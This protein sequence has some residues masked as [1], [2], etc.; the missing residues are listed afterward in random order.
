MSTSEKEHVKASSSSGNWT[1][2]STLH[3]S[4][5]EMHCAIRLGDLGCVQ[6]LLDAGDRLCTGEGHNCFFVAAKRVKTLAG[7]E[8][9]NFLKKLLALSDKKGLHS[10]NGSRFFNLIFVIREF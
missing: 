6:R 1:I 10:R 4:S 3:K 5:S 7:E 2:G 9:C 8:P